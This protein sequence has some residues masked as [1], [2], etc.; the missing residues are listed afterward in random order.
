MWCNAFS[1]SSLLPQTK[2]N[3]TNKQTKN[4][5]LYH[6]QQHTWRGRK[7]INYGHRINELKQ[8]IKICFISREQFFIIVSNK[9]F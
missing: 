2:Q 5:D 3:R 9:K 7:T 1:I 8:M 4:P 6:C